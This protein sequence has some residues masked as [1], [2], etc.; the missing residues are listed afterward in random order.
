MWNEPNADLEDEMGLYLQEILGKP[1]SEIK[2][3]IKAERQFIAGELEKLLPLK[4]KMKH[5]RRFI[6]LLQ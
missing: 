5:L 1:E 6:S 2:S 4:L 3:L